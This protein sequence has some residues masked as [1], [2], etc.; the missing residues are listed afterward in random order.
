MDSFEKA[1]SGMAQ[2]DEDEITWGEFAAYFGFRTGEFAEV[3]KADKVAGDCSMSPEEMEEAQE[4][5]RKVRA[6]AAAHGKGGRHTGVQA[7]EFAAG[8]EK[9]GAVVHLALPVLMAA[10]DGGHAAGSA[11]AMHENHHMPSGGAG[12]AAR[13]SAIGKGE[14]EVAPLPLT[15]P[16]AAS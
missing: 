12:W 9:A 15:L 6:K 10:D 11:A 7:A 1:F 14:S 8:F 4:R 2:S 3:G 5:A 16:T 13:K